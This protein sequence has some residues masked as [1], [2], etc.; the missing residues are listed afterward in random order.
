MHDDDIR[1]DYLLTND[2]ERLTN[3]LPQIREVVREATGK[4]ASD[5]ALMVAMRVEAEYLDMAFNV[6][7][8]AHGSLD[9]YLDQ[10]LG[11]DGELRARL[12]DRL[13]A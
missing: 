13:L 5:D 9:G 1:E 6:M 10:V 11:L 8:E 2:P 4:T 7:R 12:H 3:R